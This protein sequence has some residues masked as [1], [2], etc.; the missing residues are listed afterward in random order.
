MVVEGKAR[1]GT[2]VVAGGLI[3]PGRWLTHLSGWEVDL[4][5]LHSADLA[6]HVK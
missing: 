1:R 3:A 5:L 2:N 4:S 6:E